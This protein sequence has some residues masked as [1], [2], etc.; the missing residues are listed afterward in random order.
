MEDAFLSGLA[1]GE[2]LVASQRDLS[3]SRAFL[4]SGFSD[5]KALLESLALVDSV[6]A[7]ANA[8]RVLPASRSPSEAAAA[9]QPGEGRSRSRPLALLSRD[10]SLTTPLSLA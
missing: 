10:S 4:D 7:R 1:L 9:D 3:L 8:G 2:Q 5:P 6:R